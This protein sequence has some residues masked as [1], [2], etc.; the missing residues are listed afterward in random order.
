[1]PVPACVRAQE[2][3]HPGEREDAAALQDIR[4]RIRDVE[5]SIQSARDETETIMKDVQQAELDVNDAVSRL[6]EI[7]INTRARTERLG[8]LLEQQAGYQRTFSDQ[9]R[10]LAAQI[11]AA[12]TTGRHDFIK[13]LLNQEDPTLIGRMLAYHG[14][15]SRAR[16]EK[17]ET[18]RAAVVQ[19]EELERA[20]RQETLQLKHLY[21]RERAKLGELEEYRSSRNELVA[22]LQD[23]ISTRGHELE[24]LQRNEKELADL[25]E[26]LQ[27]EESIVRK[28]EDLPPFAQLKGKL[29]WP[30]NGEI[31]GRFGAPR[32]GGRLRSQ[33]ITIGAASGSEVR[34]VSI[35]TVIFADWFRNMGLLIILDHGGGYMSLYGHNESLLKKAGDLV[36]AGE[37]I[38][39]VGDTGGQDRPGL[40]FEIRLGGNPLDPGQWCSG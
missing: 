12:Y 23:Y 15:F 18:V 21:D 36:D 28:Y 29:P 26:R 1:M 19:M 4:T 11:R 38:S 32:K 37:V 5:S 22:R 6:R 8:E 31:T 13:L 35:G 39:R 30:I 25:V 7:E 20:I 33:G 16:A 17:I 34:A 14:Y 3:P 9:K 27:R 40:Y 24:I 2:V 10:R